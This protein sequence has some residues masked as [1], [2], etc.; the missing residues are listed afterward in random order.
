MV[1]KAI[2]GLNP[3]FVDP[4]AKTFCQHPIQLERKLTLYGPT[5]ISFYSLWLLLFKV[6]PKG[7]VSPHRYWAEGGIGMSWGHGKRGGVLRA[8][9]PQLSKVKWCAHSFDPIILLLIF[10]AFFHSHLRPPGVL[11]FSFSFLHSH[12]ERSFLQRLSA[13][14]SSLGSVRRFTLAEGKYY[15]IIYPTRIPSR[16]LTQK[17]KFFPFKDPQYVLSFAINNLKRTQMP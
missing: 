6:T 12:P 7:R 5:F 2:F 11:P 1:T 8:G 10:F 15:P 4:K 16:F 13:Y 9:C 14:L 3:E 17:R